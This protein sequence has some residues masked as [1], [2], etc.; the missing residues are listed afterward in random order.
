[1]NLYAA[2]ILVCLRTLSYEACT[3]ETASRSLEVADTISLESCIAQANEY[4]STKSIAA[5]IDAQ[6]FGKPYC[7][8]L[9]NSNG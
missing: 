3:P 9:T 5:R 4:W 6:H 2:L 7:L 8:P 1:M